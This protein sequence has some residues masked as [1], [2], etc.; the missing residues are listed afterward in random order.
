MH[1]HLRGHWDIPNTDSEP[2]KA[3][4]VVKGNLEEMPPKSFS[5]YYYGRT[6]PLSLPVCLPKH[7]FFLLINSL[8]VSLLSV[9]VGILFLQCQ[10]ARALS[11]TAGL[12]LRIW[13]S[14]HH[15]LASVSGQFQATVVWDHLRSDG[16][17]HS[18]TLQPK[19][20]ASLNNNKWE[21]KEKEKENIK[22][23]NKEGGRKRKKKIE[24]VNKTF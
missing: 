5:N 11:L 7:A 8:L 20:L 1:A 16:L 17:S 22:E 19:W 21:R 10:R 15:D 23:S 24:K 6:L 4:L 2:G 14:H 3:R 18:K 9:L 12:V 13:C